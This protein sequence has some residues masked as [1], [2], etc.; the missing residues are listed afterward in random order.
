VER[1]WRALNADLSRGVPS[2][3]CMHCDN[4]PHTTEHFRLV[5]GYDPASDEV[6]YHEPAE[7]GG[8][9]RR[10]P[11]QRFLGLWTFKPAGH[12][13]TLIRMRLDAPTTRRSPS[14]C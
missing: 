2:I 12:D 8:A 3:V 11:R 14:T 13:W 7:A 6:I 4:S 9:Y 5:L 1:E 10:M